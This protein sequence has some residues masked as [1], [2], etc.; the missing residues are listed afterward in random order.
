MLVFDEVHRLKGVG[1]QRAKAALSL[2]QA[3]HYRYVLTGTR[4]TKDKV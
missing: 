4:P 2:S 1:G 3:P